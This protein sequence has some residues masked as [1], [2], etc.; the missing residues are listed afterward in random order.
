MQTKDLSILIPCFNEESSVGI[1]LERVHKVLIHNTIDADIVVINNNSTDN[2]V[3]EIRK[4][5]I[6]V[7]IVSEKEQG[8]GAAYLRGIQ[9]SSGKNIIMIDADLTYDEKDIPEI[10]KLLQTSSDVVIGNRFAGTIENGSMPWL[11]QHL[12]RLIFSTLFKIYFR[13][14]LSDIHCGL[15]G[16]KRSS[17]EKIYL[18][19]TGM[20]FASELI[21][22]SIKHNLSIEEIPTNYY[23]REGESKLKTLRDGWRHLRFILLYSPLVTFFIPGIFL[24]LAGL[25]GSLLTLTNT[26][27][28]GIVLYSHSLLLFVSLVIVGYQL[29]L[30]SVFIKTYAIKHLGEENVLARYYRLFN[31]ESAGIIGILILTAGLAMYLNIFSI[32]LSSNLGELH[33]I[34]NA[35]I[36]IALVIIG[37]QTISSGFMLSVLGIK[38]QQ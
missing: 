17:L 36:G 4:T 25:L 3:A 12:G 19:T 30:F 33:Q 10:L 28:Q 23:L 16:I 24:V 1:L 29:I 18:H 14:S 7:T 31:I 13:R 37:F 27:V 8:Y 38:Q 34:N 2:S 15:R 5:N 32:W 35:I 11:H 20:E 26:P 21:I 6:P 22:Q 9:E